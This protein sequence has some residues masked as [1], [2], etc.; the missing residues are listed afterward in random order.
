MNNINIHHRTL[1]VNFS[2]EGIAEAT[3]W[4]PEV[5]HV[6]LV[7]HG[8][9]EISLEKEALG[10][11]RTST[12]RIRHGDLYRFRLNDDKELPDPVSLS[13][14]EGVHGPSQAIN[15]RSFSSDED[16]ATWKN[17]PQ[18]NYIIY[19][20]HTG[21][22][23]D[24]GNFEGIEEKLDYLKDLGITAIELLPVSQFPG[25]RNWGY[26]GVFPF[27]VQDSYGG[28]AR[29]GRLFPPPSRTSESKIGD[30]HQQNSYIC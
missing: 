9:E 6:S 13:Q 11:W 15:L 20:L 18:E 28:L 2:A 19:E 25:A 21:T 4:A 14:P 7:I 27:A 16:D 3:L 26:D 8:K 17:I 29:N 23:S 22:F 1:G 24:K 12:D 5:D 30:H 10:Y